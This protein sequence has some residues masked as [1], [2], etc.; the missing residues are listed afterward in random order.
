ME[1]KCIS[2]ADSSFIGIDFSGS[3]AKWKPSVSDPTV[4]VACI[5][6]GVP[7]KVEWLQPVQELSGGKQPFQW[8]AGFLGEREFI[9]AGIDA[10]FSIPVANVPVGGWPEL[11][12][13]A[14]RLPFVGRTF[15]KADVFLAEVAGG[16]QVK[17]LRRT[18]AL[19]SDRKINVRSTLWWKARGGAPF[20]VACLKLIAAA[21]RPPCWPWDDAQSGFLVEAFPAAQLRRWELPWQKYNGR[22]GEAVRHEI[23]DRL[24]DRVDFGPCMGVARRSADALDAILAAFAAMAVRDGRIVDPIDASDRVVRREGWIAVYD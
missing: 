22:D 9:G 4:W 15:P 17:R 21:G 7:P 11:V 14:D 20:T 13:L 12:D 19:W 24:A 23:V 5:R 6:E 1:G 10:P 3:D 8:L 16:V 18:E 2:D